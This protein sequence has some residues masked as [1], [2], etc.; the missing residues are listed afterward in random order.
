M[1]QT[2]ERPNNQSFVH[3]QVRKLTDNQKVEIVIQK[4][5]RPT[6]TSTN[7]NIAQ[8]FGVHPSLVAHTSFDSL[9]DEQK[10]LYAIRVDNLKYDAMEVTSLA[11]QK[12]K[13]LV[14]MASSASHIGGVTAAL[15]KAYEI[16][17][18]QENLSTSNVSVRSEA[19]NLMLSNGTAQDI[20]QA[21][22]LYLAASG[23]ESDEQPD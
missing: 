18:L 6:P 16:F 22:A 19:I 17:R 21:E 1:E 10:K 15:G 20:E 9:N 13:E 3:K 8:Q 11:L 5:L 14:K 7:V 2:I 23:E 12:N 4:E